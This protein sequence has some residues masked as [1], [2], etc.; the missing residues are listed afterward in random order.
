[1]N[2]TVPGKRRRFVQT[3]TREAGEMIMLCFPFD[4]SEC[5][6]LSFYTVTFSLAD[7]TGWLVANFRARR[8]SLHFEGKKTE[9]DLSTEKKNEIRGIKERHF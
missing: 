5:Q 2:F 7:W 4:N 6:G 3:E 8:K 9:E 1:M